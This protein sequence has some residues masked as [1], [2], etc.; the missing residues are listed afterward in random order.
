MQDD[1]AATT[2]VAAVGTTFRDILSTMQVRTAR[3]ALAGTTINLDVV[4]EIRF[5]HNC[6]LLREI[7]F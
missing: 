2:A 4:N 1:V 5:C 7:C 6:C 3:T